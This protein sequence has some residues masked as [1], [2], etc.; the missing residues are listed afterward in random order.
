M[1]GRESVELMLA[2]RPGSDMAANSAPSVVS[3]ATA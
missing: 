3:T 2:A 1:V